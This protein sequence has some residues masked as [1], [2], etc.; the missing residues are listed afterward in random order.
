MDVKIVK[1][2]SGG[3]SSEEFEAALSV[4]DPS[5]T[6]KPDQEVEA[7]HEDCSK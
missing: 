6:Q 2:D 1:E 4:L 3:R 5:D 7:I